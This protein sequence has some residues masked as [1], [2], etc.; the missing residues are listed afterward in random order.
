VAKPK[1]SLPALI[2]KKTIDPDYAMFIKVC[3]I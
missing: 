2:K 1:P 3:R